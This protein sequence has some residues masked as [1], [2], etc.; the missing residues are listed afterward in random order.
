MTIKCDITSINDSAS[1]VKHV[2]G[3]F[4][5]LDMSYL[6]T[7][8]TSK[9]GRRSM[10]LIKMNGGTLSRSM[11]RVYTSCLKLFFL[12]SFR[13]ATKQSSQLQEVVHLTITSGASRCQTTKPN[14]IALQKFSDQGIL[15]EGLLAYTIHV[16]GL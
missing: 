10:S 14:R 11:S 12:S 16:G 7:L 1:A 13:E 5:R 6:M 2:K 15:G 8:A 3:A 4:G 9:N